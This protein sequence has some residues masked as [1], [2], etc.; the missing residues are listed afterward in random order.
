MHKLVTFLKKKKDPTTPWLQIDKDDTRHKRPGS[1]SGNTQ[2]RIR[3]SKKDANGANH[4]GNGTV[5]S[6]KKKQHLQQLH[7]QQQQQQL[8]NQQ[9]MS[10]DEDSDDLIPEEVRSISKFID[11]TKT[12]RKWLVQTLNLSSEMIEENLQILL[13]VLNFLSRKEG[14]FYR[15]PCQANGN[16][17][18][19]SKPSSRRGTTDPA[20]DTAV[21]PQQPTSLSSSG[22]S[23][24]LRNSGTHISS[25]QQQLLQQQQQF[26]NNHQNVDG[27]NFS[28]QQLQSQLLQQQQ[29]L[30][31]SANNQQHLS[32][33][34]TRHRSDYNRIFIEPG[35][36]YQFPDQESL[37]MA[38]LVVEEEDPAKL[39]RIGTEMEIKGAYGTVYHVF[40]NNCQYNN[41]ELALKK[42]DHKS[43]RNRRNNLNEIALMRYLKHP[44]IVTYINSYEKN[45][46]EIWM[47]MEYMDGGTIKEAIQNF[48]FTEKYVAYI[49]KQILHGLEYLHSL[50]IAHRD[51]KSANIMINSKAEVKIIDFGFSIDLTTL[52]A[53]IHM[54]GSPY[55]MSPEQIQEKPHDCSVDIWSLGV[56]AAEMM[57][58]VVPH[59]RSKIKAMFLASCVGIKF[60]RDKK[61][62]SHWS[63]ELFDFLAI[64]LQMD[65]SKRP[66][67][68]TLLQHP[69]IATAATKQEMLDLLP[70]LFI[71]KTISKYSIA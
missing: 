10:S 56:M 33:Q 37:A 44:N 7:Q 63:N 39:F 11:F 58:G 65:S 27:T 69:F 45:D 1:D 41:V 34:P 70:L 4:G 9:H 52:K 14:V 24:P 42:L 17:Q 48:S 71:S 13:N 38:R 3:S 68:T 66:T 12:E 25:Q 29:Q 22:T 31:Q 40:Y 28:V 57:K 20:A 60:S 19:S 15:H 55:W 49:I 62:S 6:K 50:N 16:N 32:P 2:P 64:C 26:N 61:Y 5:S 23:S 43:E 67:P 21:Q 51:L 54:C 47:L 8:N 53:D 46:E 30:T 35:K 59:H 36:Y 18:I